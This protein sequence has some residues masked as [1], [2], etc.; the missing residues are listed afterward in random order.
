MK[1]RFTMAALIA[2]SILA[3]GCAGGPQY[4]VVASSFPP[5]AADEGRIFFFRSSSLLGVATQAPIRLDDVIVGASR[6]RGFFYVD[7]PAGSHVASAS[8]EIKTTLSFTLDAGETKYI[9]TSPGFGFV[10]G[11]IVLELEDPQKAQAEIKK[12]SFTGSLPLDEE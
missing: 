6:P 9:R 4:A 2:A 3:T 12:L 5:L 8:T 7:R 10:M 11:R 1:T